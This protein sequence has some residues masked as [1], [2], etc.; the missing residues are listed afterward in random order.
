MIKV[1][2]FLVYA[3]Y[4]IK[5]TKFFKSASKIGTDKNRQNS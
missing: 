4:F 2:F 3:I 1:A 5:L